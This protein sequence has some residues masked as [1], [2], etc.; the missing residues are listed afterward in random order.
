MYPTQSM[1]SPLKIFIE[2]SIPIY[3]SLDPC[4]F[5]WQHNRYRDLE[6]YEGYVRCVVEPLGWLGLA[7]TLGQDGPQMTRKTGSVG[8]A[9][10]E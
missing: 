9:G 3:A 7:S 5:F 8:Q 4:A 10:F 2:G 6:S 1:H